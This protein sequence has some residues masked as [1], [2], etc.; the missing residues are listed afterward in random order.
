MYGLELK[1]TSKNGL[2]TILDKEILANS[3]SIN[4]VIGFQIKNKKHNRNNLKTYIKLEIEHDSLVNLIEEEEIKIS[5]HV[6]K[7]VV[8]G[9]ITKEK[10]NEFLKFLIVKKGDNPILDKIK[11][12]ITKLDRLNNPKKP[13]VDNT[14]RLEEINTQIDVLKNSLIIVD[15]VLNKYAT[16]NITTLKDSDSDLIYLRKSKSDIVFEMNELNEN[17]N[18]YKTT[19]IDIKLEKYLDHTTWKDAKKAL[20]KIIAYRNSEK[21]QLNNRSVKLSIDKDIKQLR[22]LY[23]ALLCTLEKFKETKEQLDELI[24]KQIDYD[25]Y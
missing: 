8:N 14:K 16:F 10:E 25:K 22:I 5:S 13:D 15:D 21:I 3:G 17:H 23:S 1:C 20:E 19:P 9:V 4:G 18:I 24:S 2:A 12:I 7:M 11:E 6:S